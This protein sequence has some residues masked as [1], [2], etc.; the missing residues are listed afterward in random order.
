MRG[1]FDSSTTLPISESLPIRITMAT[2][3]LAVAPIV[4]LMPAPSMS[5]AATTNTTSAIPPAVAAVVALR[6]ARLRTL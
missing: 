2:S 4:F 5:E 1:M 3:G 6:T